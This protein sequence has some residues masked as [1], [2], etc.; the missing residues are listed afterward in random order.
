MLVTRTPTPA[1]ALFSIRRRTERFL[2]RLR[3]VVG[4]LTTCEGNVRMCWGAEDPS[5]A[6]VV[7]PLNAA[8]DDL[9]CRMVAAY[10]PH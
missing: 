2:E 3:P 6:F 1:G 5:L 4:F 8:E 10:M 7:G 9:L